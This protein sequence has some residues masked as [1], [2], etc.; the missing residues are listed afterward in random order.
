[1][2]IGKK[3]KRKRNYQTANYSTNKNR[4][5]NVEGN[6]NLVLLHV[7]KDSLHNVIDRK[8]ILADYFHWINE[9]LKIIQ[10]PMKY[11]TSKYILSQKNG[12]RIK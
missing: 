1:M 3:V 10:D 2:H 9:T 11:G 6:F 8:R 4:K 7:F 5:V 12:A